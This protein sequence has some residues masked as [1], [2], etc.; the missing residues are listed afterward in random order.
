MSAVTVVTGAGQGI[1]AATARQLAAAGTRLVLVD[2]RPEG[3]TTLASDLDVAHPVDGGHLIAPLDVTDAAAVAA[4]GALL[5]SGG[6]R[7]AGVV[8]AA[9]IISRGAAEHFER[10]A[11]DLHLAVHLTG[12]FTL[13]QVLH[14]LMG[15]GSSV[16]NIA[17][18][19]STFG[20]P[21]RIAYTTAKSGILGLTRTLAS[22]WGRQ[23]IRVNAVAPGYVRTEMVLSGLR[24]GTLD[25]SSLVARTPLGRLAEPDEIARAIRFLLSDDAAFINGATLRVDGGLTID[26]AFD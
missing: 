13:L 22:E 12:A 25:E 8:S 5:A 24:A 23:G 17:S 20:L 4:F 15:P 21:G 26:G 2:L 18:V 10:A 19:G 11:W 14:P 7:V 16:V 9:G 1:G 6:L 3:I